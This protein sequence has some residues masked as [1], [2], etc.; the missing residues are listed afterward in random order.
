MADGCSITLLIAASSTESMSY[1][2][3]FLLNEPLSVGP[4]KVA[5]LVRSYD[6]EI[7]ARTSVIFF[8]VPH[9]AGSLPRLAPTPAFANLGQ[10]CASQS[11]CGN[12]SP[13][14]RL[15]L[16]TLQHSQIDCSNRAR[17]LE[18]FGENNA[19]VVDIGTFDATEISKLAD[20][21]AKI[22]A[23]EATPSKA[24][25][26]EQELKDAG[27]WHKVVLFSAAASNVSG[28]AKL[29]TPD[30]AKGSEMDSLGTTFF[31][32]GLAGGVLEVQTLRV[33]SVV[34]EHVAM[35]KTDTQGHE[36]HVLMGAEGLLHNHGVDIL[37]VEFAPRLLMANGVD[38]GDLLNFIYDNGYRCFDC[39]G[40]DQQEPPD[41]S[42]HRDLDLYD[43][44]FTPNIDGAGNVPGWDPGKF[45]DLICV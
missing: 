23:F 31:Y 20:T 40:H 34:H 19:V 24:K 30:G 15:V 26:I 6:L 25:R 13:K 17:L 32:A 4:H 36:L 39:P 22:Y 9:V 29:F 14:R 38:P 35:L 44:G 10:R 43:I 16:P 1:N 12:P 3:S 8:Y 18:G 28:T 45:T 33:D 2:A 5:A 21:A 37:L 7:L 11:G 27:H 42:W 41:P